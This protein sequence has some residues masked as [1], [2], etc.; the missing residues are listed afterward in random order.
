MADLGDR[1]TI[2][3][4]HPAADAAREAAMELTNRRQN[5]ADPHLDLEPLEQRLNLSTLHV[6]AAPRAL[7]HTSTQSRSVLTAKPAALVTVAATRAAKSSPIG[8]AATAISGVTSIP[9]PSYSAIYNSQLE[10]QNGVPDIG[11]VSWAGAYV[12]YTVTAPAAGTYS[13][14]LSLANPSHAALQISV[15]GVNGPIIDANATGSWQ[16]FNATST[17]LQLAAGTNVIRFSSLYGTQYNLANLS[18]TPVGSAISIGDTTS[19]PITAYSA[20]TG[21]RIE[22]N[23][24]TPDIGYV[25]AS[26]ATVDYNLNIATSG[27]YALTIGASAVNNNQTFNVLDNGTKVATFTLNNTG[28]WQT[29]SNFTQ[30][31]SLAAGSH[32]LRLA[33]TNGS[34][35]NL[36]SLNLVRQIPAANSAASATSGPAFTIAQRW[37]TS[38]TELDITQTAANTALTV[39]QSGNTFT[40]SANGQSQ[41]VTGSFG[42]LVVYAGSGNAAATVAASVNIPATI[43]SGA[44]SDM[45]TNLTSAQATIVTLDGYADSVIGNGINTAFWVSPSDTVHASALELANGDV[46]TIS[47]FYQPYT[48]TPGAA[49]YVTNIRDGSN[50]IDPTSAGSGWTRLTSSS[51]WGT[52]PTMQDINQGFSED[53]Y[54]LSTLQSLAQVQP[55]KLEQMAVDLGDGTYAVQFMRGGKATY[56]R[57]DAD[58]PTSPYGGLYYARTGG[59]GDEW[60]PIMEKAYA[61]FRT[62]SNSYA[63]LDFGFNNTVYSDFGIANTTL[64][65]PSD[66]NSFYSTVSAKLSASKGVDILTN[67]SIV[68]SAPL[69]ASHCYSVTAI[70]KDASGTVWVTLRN[71]WGYDG[72]NDDSNPWDGF[73]TITYATLQANSTFASLMA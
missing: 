1:F 59:S 41:T 33:S 12:E 50:L 68:S 56:V 10:Y 53:C 71:P 2:V 70:S 14:G 44:G 47:S 48:S 3:R 4:G 26:G 8:G 5:I 22:Y 40:V 11:Y 32:T 25:S 38:F 69:V 9:V 63:S 42:D 34:Q 30:N 66:Q 27:T 65:L 35:Y 19:V 73:V 31:I 72:F 6:V 60:A 52:G 54:F 23:G 61:Y 28:G 24:S 67:V 13:L 21:S 7:A 62:A 36:L 58:L 55:G 43:Y 51:L 57:V 18:L 45:L 15:N 16:S 49:G 39:S 17:Q 46:H 29:Y 20:I 37:M 64:I